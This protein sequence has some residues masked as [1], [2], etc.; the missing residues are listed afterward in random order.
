MSGLIL[1]TKTADYR[2][3]LYSDDSSRLYL[4]TDANPAKK[5]LIAQ[6]TDC[7]DVFQEPGVAND[8]GITYPT[9]EPVRLMAGQQYYVEAVWK[10]GVGGDY[11]L[12]AWREEGDGTPASSLAAM[13]GQYLATVVDP[14]VDL[15]FVTQPADQVGTPP[16]SSINVFSQN[17]AAGDG[18]F[19]VVNTD[20][21]PPGPW[22]WNG[23]TWAADGAESG[24][25]GP[26]NSQL[27]GPTNTVAQSG[28][29]MLTFNHRYSFE[30]GLWD[31]GQVRISVNGGAFTLVPAGNF[32]TNGYAEGNIIGSGIANGLRAFNGD[33]PDYASGAFITSQ[34]ILGSFSA[35]DRLVVQF[36]GAWDDCTTG[37]VPGW[38]IQS[39]KVELLVGAEQSTFTAAASATRRGEPVEVRYQ[40]QRNDGPGW[41]DIPGATSAAYVI[42]PSQVDMNATFRVRVNAYAIPGRVIYSDVVRLTVPRPTIEVSASGAGLSIL[43]TGT[44]QSSP[45]VDGTYQNVPGA[46]SPYPV[47]GPTGNMFYRSVK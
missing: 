17:F 9:S 14:N 42:T 31:A 13:P 38:E 3:F 19:T 41:A 29:V 37:S 25:T 27:I 6:E 23:A 5:T 33:S 24:C 1:P 32:L 40:W 8:D 7:C 26:Y 18:G 28:T 16:T 47:T 4:S 39:M 10:E 2:F 36:L 21:A 46:T 11:C 45:T 22:V 35:G 44:L 12:V 43:Y 15:A 30:G 34:A 20:P